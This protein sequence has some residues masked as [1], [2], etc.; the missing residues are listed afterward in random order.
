M[1]LKAVYTLEAA[2]VISICMLVI[3]SAIAL[4]Y[5]IYESSLNYVA[6][7]TPQEFDAALRF[8]EL[9]A[10]KELFGDISD[11][12]SNLTENEKGE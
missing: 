6:E 1:R 4:S 3:G 7:T 10:G 5:H 9:N 8:R 2:W 12:V 11:K